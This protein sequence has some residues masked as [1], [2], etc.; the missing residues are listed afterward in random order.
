VLDAVERHIDSGG[1]TLHVAEQ[2]HG[3]PVLVLHGFAG[4]ARAMAPIVG[5]LAERYRVIAP[6]LIGHGRS[7][8]PH[9]AS[10]YAWPA[11]TSGVVRLLDA[12]ELSQAHVLGFS[13]GGRI[14]LQLAALRPTRVRALVTIGSRCAWSNESERSARRVSDT[15]LAEK[16]ERDGFAAAFA[17]RA[18]DA[19]ALHDLAPRAGAHGLALVLRHL[20]AADQPDPATAL[21][22]SA[23]PLLLIAGSADV[24]PLAAAHALAATLPEARVVEIAGAT[25]RAHLERTALV[26]RAAIDFFTACDAQR[27][28]HTTIRAAHA[29]GTRG[30]ASW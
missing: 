7:D 14:A 12:L 11:V 24:G 28:Q 21:A 22:R 25:H 29:A 23:T 8:A 4:S 19:D 18:I 2:G 15:A 16:I 5:A 9:D 1:V 27:T 26:A 17:D 10:A 6:D 13:L 30:E 20:G 3:A